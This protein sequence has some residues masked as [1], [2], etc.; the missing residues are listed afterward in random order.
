[1]DIV[2]NYK[3]PSCG[4]AL[5]FNASEGNVT[6]P[7]CDSSFDVKEIEQ[8]YNAQ[9]HDE[10][11]DHIAQDATV[12][13]GSFD[14]QDADWNTDSLNENWGADSQ[15][16][17]QYSCPSCGASLICDETTAATSCP[18]CD[19]PMVMQQQFSGSLKP[20]YIIPFKIE[21]KDAVEALKN[22]YNGK[23]LLPDEFANQNHLDEIKGIYVPFWFF[24]GTAYGSAVFHA[25]TTHTHRTQNATVITTKNYKC[26]R[27]GN[28]SFSMVPVD[29]SKKMD[30]ALMDSLEPFNYKEIKEFSTGYLPGYL[31]NIPD[32]DVKNCF[33]RANVRCAA[34]CIDALEKTVTGYETVR[35][36]S[37]NVKL[38]QGSVHYGLIPVWILNTHCDGKKYVYAVNGQ[39]GKVVGELPI[40][41]SKVAL[42]FFRRFFLTLLIGGAVAA[43]VL[44]FMGAF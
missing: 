10:S 18:Y 44:Y 29:A 15:G 42:R 41:S 3:C 32:D 22:F 38:K 39:S 33:S 36:T 28:I 12:E 23:P 4:G 8:L 11:D 6:C 7:Y 9:N 30:N 1:M 2:K 5:T 20:D 19:N 24:D 35:L 17:K 13:A 27:D 16:M 43:L 37:K 25:T 40:S 34:T 26:Y 14:S 31:A 21:K